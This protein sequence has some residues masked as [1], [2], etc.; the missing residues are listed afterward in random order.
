MSAHAS[1]NTVRG[2]RRFERRV[3][4]RSKW[5]WR[6]AR[7]LRHRRLG[8]PRRLGSPDAAS[9][10]FAR[11]ELD[12]GLTWR[13]DRVAYFETERAF[14]LL[15]RAL[16]VLRDLVNRVSEGWHVHA[17]ALDEM[18]SQIGVLVEIAASFERRMELTADYSGEIDVARGAANWM[19]GDSDRYSLAD[20]SR[21][22]QLVNDL[23][24][25]LDRLDDY[26]VEYACDEE[27]ELHASDIE[28]VRADATTPPP[29][30][31][32]DHRACRTPRRAMLRVRARRMVRARRT[33][34][35]RTTA[36]PPSSDS[37]SSDGPAR[38]RTCAIGGAP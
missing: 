37:D 32:R 28:R 15:D 6:R 30:P 24:D 11:R 38:R 20:R 2:P 35:V 12:Y 19:D 36:G 22:A 16:D 29:L 18:S 1:T 27:L 33:R 14:R 5:R 31:P 17:N 13:A 4:R 10:A 23:D 3:L 26:L 8:Q 7:R 21:A 34:V 9:I 25:E